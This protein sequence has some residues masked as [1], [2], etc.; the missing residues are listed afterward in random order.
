MGC[1]PPSV[2]IALRNLLYDHV[3]LTFL[4]RNFWPLFFSIASIY[5]ELW[6][7]S[8]SNKPLNSHSAPPC[9]TFDMKLFILICSVCQHDTLHYDQT[10][11]ILS[12][13]F[14]E[15]FLELL[16]FIQMEI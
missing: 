2:I 11:L 13:L 10:S 5:K 16:L 15:R 4:W 9:L 6:A 1:K 12:Y 8:F 3:S 14:K 7:F